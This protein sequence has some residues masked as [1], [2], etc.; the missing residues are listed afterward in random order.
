MLVWIVA[1]VAIAVVGWLAL[2]SRFGQNV[3]R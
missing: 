1:I 2:D 3:P